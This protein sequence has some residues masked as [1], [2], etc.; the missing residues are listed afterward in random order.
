[1]KIVLYP[2]SSDSSVPY[3]FIKQI[4]L[5]CPK[6]GLTYCQLWENKNSKNLVKIT[7]EEVRTRYLTDLGKFRHD[8]LQL[9][10]EGLLSAKEDD[11]SFL[12]QLVTMEDVGGTGFTLC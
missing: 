5:H 4:F 11:N 9:E 1:M 7:Q 12:I 10:R 8:I 6:A 2:E 3:L